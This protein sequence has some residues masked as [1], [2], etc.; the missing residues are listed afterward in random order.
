LE[1]HASLPDA[2]EKLR[3][4]EET[5]ATLAAAGYVFIGMDHFARPEDPLARALRGGTLTRN[6]QGYSTCGDTDL[7][8]FGA[9]SI[10]SVAGGYAQNA[11]GLGD[12]SARVARE[13][14]ATCR[15]LVLTAE[16]LLRRD[17]IM[18]LMCHS[19]LPKREIEAAHGIDF[20]SHFASELAALRPF[21]DDGL[22]ELRA[23]EL[24]VTSAGRLLVRNLA[25]VFDSY[26]AAPSALSADSAPSAPS[27]VRYSRTV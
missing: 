2:E 17:I 7:V 18:R 16:D 4:L 10:S 3:L 1:R 24:A 26:L 12:Y 19:L 27:R 6:F 14:L 20:D 21:A 22:V 15:G 9:S 25:M 8:A 13:R 5:S 23:E 11:H